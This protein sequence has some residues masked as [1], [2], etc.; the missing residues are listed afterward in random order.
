MVDFNA[1][2]VPDEK[3]GE[4]PPIIRSMNGF[5]HMISTTKIIEMSYKGPWF[6][7]D[8]RQLGKD[9]ILSKIDRGFCNEVLLFK[10]TNNWIEIIASIVSDPKTLCAQLDF[11]LPA[12]RS[13]FRHM[14]AWAKLEG[15]KEI[16]TEAW[17][18]DVSG[19]PMFKVVSKLK[20]VK[21]ELSAWIKSQAG[22]FHDQAKKLKEQADNTPKL[23]D[24]CPDNHDLQLKLKEDRLMA[25]R[26]CEIEESFLRQKIRNIQLREEIR[27]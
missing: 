25:D 16:I 8:N 11:S 5:N 3:R 22:N 4:N 18:I 23:Y 7:G 12:K 6:T 26:A 14:N 1:V 21:V 15:Y 27:I 17:M 20:K 24:T 19:C 9:S 2:R 13:L 10:C